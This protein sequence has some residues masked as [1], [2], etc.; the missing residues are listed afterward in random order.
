MNILEIT[1]PS[2]SNHSRDSTEIDGYGANGLRSW[3]EIFNTA[4]RALQETDQ[5]LY[6]STNA[7]ME[8]DKYSAAGSETEADLYDPKTSAE[9]GSYQYGSNGHVNEVVDL[10]NNHD[11]LSQSNG[12]YKDK[13][14][15][16]VSKTQPTLR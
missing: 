10:L 3:E 15:G 1:P 7:L 16:A 6:S 5:Y 12:T 8:I 4:T 13:V 2:I 9:I 14:S 11:W